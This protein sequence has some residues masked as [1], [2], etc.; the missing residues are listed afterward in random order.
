MTD[1]QNPT[2]IVATEYFRVKAMEVSNPHTRTHLHRAIDAFGRITGSSS[3]TL[4]DIDAPLIN[5]WVSDL[6]YHGYRQSSILTYLSKISALYGKAVKEG[7][8]GR[9]D[10]FSAVTAR[11][12]EIPAARLNLWA[13]SR[14]FDRLRTL[15]GKDAPRTAYQQLARDIIMFSVYNGGLTFQQL[16]AYR[17]TDYTGDSQ[18]ILDIVSRYSRPKNRYLFPLRQ[19]ER[20]P[21]QLRSVIAALFKDGLASVGIRAEGC[22]DSLASDL[23]SI[24][25]KHAGFPPGSIAGCLCNPA[26]LWPF[27]IPEALTSE[28]IARIRRRVIEVLE[29]DPE[30]WYA[31][32]FRPRVSYGMIS[33][34]MKSS[35]V[36]FLSEFY[37]M[38]EIVRRVGR[39]LISQERPV[40]P[41]LLFFKSRASAL[42]ALF[43]HVGDLAWGYR[44]GRS[45]SSYAVIPPEAIAEYQCAVGKFSDGIGEYPDGIL[46]IEE[47]DRVMITDGKFGG[48]SAVFE[49]E[50][51]ERPG[52]GDRPC[53]IVYRLRLVG[54]S[55]YT[56]TVDLDPRLLKKIPDD[57]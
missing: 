53:R 4:T 42:G 17:K 29:S 20:T 40:M 50:V 56:W 27:A 30:E 49:K 13:D 7:L 1:S 52:V 2:A 46:Q 47:G 9:N 16:G 14:T 36:K 34:R 48:Y 54:M 55:N 38:E 24:A 45:G 15:A 5:R 26:A 28:R 35:P 41:G 21:C 57:T 43:R 8:V 11:I 31:M 39:K 25:A 37:P 51:C 23:W 3:L 10:C 33:E 19:S 44:T 18:A 12:R 22:P 6:L 32:Q